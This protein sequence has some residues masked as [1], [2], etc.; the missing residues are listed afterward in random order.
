[1]AQLAKSGKQDK[2]LTC[3]LFGGDMKNNP[4]CATAVRYTSV[5]NQF[6]CVMF[7]H[8]RLYL[9]TIAVVSFTLQPF[10]ISGKYK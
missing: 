2:T 10:T 3:P 8:C 1:V 5:Q 7:Y 6:W 9:L 4:A